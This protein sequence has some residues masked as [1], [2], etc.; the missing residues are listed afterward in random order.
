[1]VLSKLALSEKPKRGEVLNDFFRTINSGIE[2]V[3]NNNIRPIYN[4]APMRITTNRFQLAINE[5]PIDIP[6]E[7]IIGL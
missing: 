1:V 4:M 7:A 6:I 2:K 5:I 3:L